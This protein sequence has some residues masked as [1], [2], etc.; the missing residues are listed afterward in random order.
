MKARGVFAFRG[1]LGKMNQKRGNS[2]IKYDMW[3]VLHNTVKDQGDDGNTRN[4]KAQVW[5]SLDS[6]FKYCNKENWEEKD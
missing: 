5:R 3:K 6:I 1:R 4:R 2:T